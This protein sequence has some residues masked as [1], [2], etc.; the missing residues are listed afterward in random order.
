MNISTIDHLQYTTRSNRFPTESNTASKL[1]IGD[2]LE[3]SVSD[4]VVDLAKQKPIGKR[5]VS[6][7]VRTPVFGWDANGDLLPLSALLNANSPEVHRLRN[8]PSFIVK[9]EIEQKL[10]IYTPCC[11]LRYDWGSRLY[12]PVC[13]TCLCDFD[14]LKTDN[15]SVDFGLLKQELSELPQVYYCGLAANGKD[16][17][18]LVPIL[19][20]QRYE[21]HALAL[22]ILF[23]QQGITISTDVNI[24]HTRTVSTDPNGYFNEN[25]VEFDH[26]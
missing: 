15:P 17:F 22:R 25:A 7:Y 8:E 16:L 21:E 18:C 12:F 13:Y 20:P 2:G 3:L 5:L 1:V 10:P 19:V 14:I 6:A 4:E 9:M 23:K 26:L 11:V 24:A